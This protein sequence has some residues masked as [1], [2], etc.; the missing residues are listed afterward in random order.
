MNKPTAT[1]LTALSMT[2]MLACA[3]FGQTFPATVSGSGTVTIEKP[4]EIMRITVDLT[5]KHKQLKGAIAKLKEQKTK[6]LAQ[7]N[8]K[9]QERFV[10]LIQYM[11]KLIGKLMTK[12]EKLGIYEET[13][14]IFCGDNG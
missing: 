9:Q 2:V 13:Y 6:A 5:A 7:Y 8:R 12:A 3:A 11:D 1:G 4:A 10:N 14:F